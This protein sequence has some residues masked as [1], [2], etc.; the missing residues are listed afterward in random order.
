MIW[1]TRGVTAEKERLEVLLR[2]LPKWHAA[3]QDVLSEVYSDAAGSGGEE[4][5]DEYFAASPIP[6]PHIVLHNVSLKSFRI[7]QL[8]SLMITSWCLYVF[9]VKNMGG[10]LIFK[11]SPM[12][13]EQQKDDGTVIGRKSPIE[14]ISTNEWLF[15]E[16]LRAQ[17]I[18]L[19]IRSVLVLS[20]P[21]QI[22]ENVPETQVTIFSHQLP[23][24]LHKLQVGEP[25][26]TLDDMKELARAITDAL[27]PYAPKPICANPS[28][29]IDSMLRGVWCAGCSRLGM[30]RRYGSWHCTGCGVSSKDAHVRTIKDWLLLTGEP[31]TNKLCREIL[32]IEDR[33][34]VKRLLNGMKMQKQGEFKSANYVLERSCSYFVK[35]RS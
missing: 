29:S 7:F 19:P 4:R 2:R 22:A 15:E 5:F 9:E 17:G 26:M 30:V 13:M 12:Q 33:H 6:F 23:M 11:A 14:Q 27:V 25:L 28:Y 31:V 16:W 20:Y 24:F 10:R 32:G 18:L 1:K 3:Y 8:D 21:K 35:S 34:L